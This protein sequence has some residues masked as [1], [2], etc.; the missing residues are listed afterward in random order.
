MRK[1]FIIAIIALITVTL[2]N[3][4]AVTPPD[5]DPGFLSKRITMNINGCDFTVLLCYQCTPTGYFDGAIYLNGYQIVDPNC[6]M[7]PLLNNNQI[8]ERIKDNLADAG[9]NLLL[10]LCDKGVPPCTETAVTV[11][12]FIP[13]CWAKY[14]LGP[15]LVRYAPCLPPD[16]YCHTVWAYCWDEPTQTYHSWIYHGPDQHGTP[17]C[18]WIFPPDPINIGD[19]SDCFR[20]IT[21]CDQ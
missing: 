1:M 12:F 20:V 18:D 5:C 2:T 9:M 21:D 4:K 19:V 13:N 7:N 15:N 10:E 14:R 16:E 8:V 3:I 6:V 17:D 11:Q